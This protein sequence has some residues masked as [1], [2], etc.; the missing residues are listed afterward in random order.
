MLFSQE[1]GI[2]D[3]KVTTKKLNK[4]E[5]KLIYNINSDGVIKFIISDEDDLVVLY[6]LLTLGCEVTGQTCR[7]VTRSTNTGTTVTDKLKVLIRVKA[8]RIEYGD[9]VTV[10]GQ[11]LW[12][13]NAKVQLGHYHTLQF[14]VGD[15]VS[16][17]RKDWDAID[18]KRIEEAT[19]DRNKA[20]LV[21]VG[22]EGGIA[23]LW[24]VSP[25]FIKEK[26]TI[27]MNISKK[28]KY[29]NK[30]DDQL[31]SFYNMVY[32]VIK[33]DVNFDQITTLI[34]CGTFAERE[35]L[36]TKMKEIAEKKSDNKMKEGLNRSI[37]A[38]AVNGVN[39]A[40]RDVLSNPE[41]SKILNDC[42]SYKDM[43][44]IMMFDEAMR[45]SDRLVAIGY[46]D[47]IK[48][49]DA[50]AIK[51]L[52]IADNL[53]RVIGI[54]KRLQICQIVDDL[55]ER[56]IPIKLLSSKTEAGA[57]VVR[58]GGIVAILKYELTLDDE[59]AEVSEDYNSDEI[60][61][62]GRNVSEAIGDAID[63]DQ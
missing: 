23:K 28:R 29:N 16:I 35:R 46:N 20:T 14:A 61:W 33:K 55:K 48:A 26:E 12:C 1:I 59:D 43:C 11:M 45:K 32:N 51:V 38:A 58:F 4:I 25:A 22:V 17:M 40:I 39:F 13:N 50:S 63:M 7:K 19:D 5:M 9:I 24:F 30:H 41:L 36:M 44:D 10:T 42:R 54:E 47:I 18:K 2:K 6:Q 34:F 3:K 21:V 57:E 31:E 8:E 37:Q 52:F 62:F 56:K 49:Y 60:D 15:E 53:T 27:E